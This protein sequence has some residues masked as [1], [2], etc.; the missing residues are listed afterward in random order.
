MAEAT[1]VSEHARR[2]VRE[3]GVVN[4][5]GPPIK[6]YDG[7]ME[8]RQPPFTAEVREPWG[9]DANGGTYTLG[10]GTVTVDDVHHADDCACLDDL[11]LDHAGPE[12]CCKQGGEPDCWH[13]ICR[14]VMRAQCSQ[15]GE[16]LE[17]D[18]WE[19]GDTHNAHAPDCNG[20]CARCPVP[21]GPVNIT[22]EDDL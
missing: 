18:R 2:L 10:H 9:K 8:A 4:R 17:G 6:K 12:P 3:G 20:G 15:C 14:P 11:S 21:C 19:D 16:R 5:D 7:W 22:G 13:W 1:I